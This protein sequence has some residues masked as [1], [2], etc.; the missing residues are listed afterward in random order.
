MVDKQSQ[1][2]EDLGHWGG[3]TL[4][5][6]SIH[7][8]HI[9][10]MAKRDAATLTQERKHRELSSLKCM[11]EFCSQEI[12]N[13]IKHQRNSV[14]GCTYRNGSPAYNQIVRHSI[15]ALTCATPVVWQWGI[16]YC[17]VFSGWII[18]QSSPDDCKLYLIANFIQMNPVEALKRI[19]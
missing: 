10:Q 14:H 9:T 15:P 5:V 2:G 1:A 19:A 7:A 17:R 11:G 18:L 6:S 3:T 4:V 12:W 13:N 16:P 8:V